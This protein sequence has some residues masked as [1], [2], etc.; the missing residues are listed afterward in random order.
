MFLAAYSFFKEEKYLEA[1]RRCG[2][3][4]WHR[5]LILKG[6]GLCHGITGNIYP[7]LTLAKATKDK[8]WMMRA[9][10]FATLSFDKE[11]MKKCSAA[12]DS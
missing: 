5:G 10:K 8:K 12:S 4:I 6:N 1:A 11:V 2:E 9:Y 7:F 3:A